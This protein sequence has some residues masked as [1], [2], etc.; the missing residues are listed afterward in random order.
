MRTKILLAV[1][2]T[3]GLAAIA[4][5]YGDTSA[6][7]TLQDAGMVTE[8]VPTT[9]PD[10]ETGFLDWISAGIKAG[11]TGNWRM[12][13]AL[14]LMGAV[15]ALRK[16]GKKFVPWFGTGTGGVVLSIA[17][18]FLVA[19]AGVISTGASFGLQAILGA[20]LTAAA[21]SGLFSWGKTLAPEKKTPKPV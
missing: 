2:I 11:T 10:P 20:L 6:N 15:V 13:A 7:S 12:L 16:W 3:L 8:P 5:A 14:L 18:G 9:L 21:A 1:M 19:L 4:S 17:G